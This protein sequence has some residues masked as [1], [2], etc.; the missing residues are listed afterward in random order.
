MIVK[1]DGGYNYDSTD[2][3]CIY[4]RIH[5]LKCNR[6]IYITDAGQEQ[7]FFMIFEAAKM[8]GW[9]NKQ[10]NIRVDHMGFG[11]V[12]DEETGKKFKTREGEVVKLEDLLDEARNRALL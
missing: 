8:M 7:H 12:L 11:V 10:N 3:A 4:Y 1:S 5:V 6:I 9:I 2:M